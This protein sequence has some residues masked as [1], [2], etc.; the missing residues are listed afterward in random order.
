PGAHANVG[1]GYEDDQLPDPPLKWLADRAIQCGL[2]F[3]REFV[4]AGCTMV[5]P[6]D[7]EL[8]GNEYLGAVRDSYKEMAYGI[9]AGISVIK[10]LFKNKTNG[11]WYRPMLVYGVNEMIDET[12]TLKVAR[13]SDYRPPNL[14]HVGRDD[15]NGAD[16][17][18]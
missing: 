17:K 14:A 3:R 9:Y 10:A 7:F 1:G 4:D 6:R 15:L 18:N 13:D 12:A 8:T 16:P 5:L 11:R 2:E